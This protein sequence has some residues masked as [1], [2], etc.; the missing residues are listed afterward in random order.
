[1]ILWK[2]YYAKGH[3]QKVP[4]LIGSTTNE[5][6]IF[7]CSVFNGTANST[8]VQEF[9][10]TQYNTTIV[11][12]IPKIYGPVS[13]YDNPLTYLNIVFSDAWAH[14]G[15]RRMASKFSIYGPPSYLYTYNHIIPVAPPCWGVPHAAELPMI[16]PSFLSVFFPNYNF[17]A[18][19][20]QL[21]RN[22]MLYW[23]NFIRSGNPNYNGSPAKW[24]T[25]L[26]SSDDDFV[27]DI[28][29]RMRN[30]YYDPPCSR[31]WDLYAVTNSTFVPSATRSV[32]QLHYF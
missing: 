12:E 24:D 20:Q 27:L 13:T 17:T 14:C 4:L 18:L 7:T 1:M 11:D 3:F 30:D 31:L 15:S 29:P 26:T 28:N 22:M 10:N 19:E 32:G 16:F 25:Y 23:A 6:S 8:Q 5:T 21:S 2:N 9:L